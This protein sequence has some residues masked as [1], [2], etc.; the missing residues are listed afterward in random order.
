MTPYK[1]YLEQWEFGSYE[2]FLKNYKIIVPDHFNFAFDVLDEMAREAPDARALQW[3][4]PAG[5]ERSFTFADISR[6][7]NRCANMLASLGVKRGDAVMLVLK[8]HYEFWFAIM[9]LHKLGAVAVPATHLLTKKD[10]VYRANA[11]DISAVIGTVEG[12]FADQLD[13]ALPE[14]PT[15]KLRIAVRGKREGW[16]SFDDEMAKH[17][18]T[19]KRPLPL[20]END[21][22]LLIYFTSGTSG[23]PKMVLHDYAYPLGHIQTAVYWLR[24]VEGGLHLTVS[25]TGWAKSVWGK[26]YG[27]WLAGSAVMSYDFEKFVPADMLRILE[28]YKVTTFCAP[29]TVYR[30]MALEDVSQYDLS[31]LKYCATAGEPLNPDLFE[32]WQRLTGHQMREIY[33]QT[34]LC[35]TV[36]TF[37]W[38]KVCPGSMG[39]PSPQFDVDLVDENGASVPP[40]VVGEIVVRTRKGRPVGMF[41]GYHRDPE[42][43]KAVWYDDAYHTLDLAWR[44]EWGYYWYVGRADDVIK[45]S[46]YRIGPF[47]V[48][49]ALLEH[50]AVV[51]TAITGVPDPVRGQ[52][53]KAT[54]VLRKGYEPSEA[55]IKELQEHV[56]RTTA[57]YKYPRIIEFVSELPKTISGKIRRVEL[58]ERDAGK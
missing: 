4:N 36:G 49:S 25:E 51:E 15:L 28:R 55:L 58:R 56:K 34:E 23:M 22:P 42:R 13:A 30:F 2:D 50:P 10:I 31:S 14:C 21:D 37:P 38:M 46:G 54:V 6:E 35:V 32:K 5:E 3:C 8:R 12:E 52:I 26:L 29:P 39:K 19:F 47:E 44:D 1:K 9:A 24:C 40:G 16:L 17:G 27:Q 48:E 41:H 57:P 33:G 53:I 7:S 18:D 45:S 43:T 20:N 11:A